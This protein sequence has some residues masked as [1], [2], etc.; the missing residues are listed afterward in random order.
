MKNDEITGVILAGGQARRMQGQDKG[1]QLLQGIPL[2]QHV[3]TRLTPQVSRVIVSAN[4]NVE[5]YERSGLRVITDTLPDYPGPLAGMLAAMQNIESE[6]F[7]FCPCDTPH[8]P[9][10]LALKLWQSRQDA[11]AVWA[12]D[13]ERDHPTVALLHRSL[14][15]PLCDYLKRGE[16]RVMQFLREEGG[17]SVSFSHQ[18]K[19]FINVN[20]TDDLAYWQER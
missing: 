4:R 17:H 20:T 12:H 19:S 13:G 6:W 1:L 9:A 16:R 8:I 15:T 14:K 10:D 2:W 7:L 18:A 3:A 5:E 11:Y